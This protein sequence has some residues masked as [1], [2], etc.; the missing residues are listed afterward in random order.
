MK[1]GDCVQVKI[2]HWVSPGLFG[3]IVHDLKG[4]G[5]AFRVLLS[6]GKVKPMIAKN[7][8]LVRSLSIKDSRPEGV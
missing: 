1:K 8:E 4:A 7:L 5:K 3:L 2:L 6:D